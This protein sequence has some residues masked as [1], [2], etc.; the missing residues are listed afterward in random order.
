M[1][2]KLVFIANNKLFKDRALDVTDYVVDL[3]Q[4]TLTV[5]IPI[6]LKK[7]TSWWKICSLDMSKCDFY[8]IYHG[9]MIKKCRG[10][11]HECLHKDNYHYRVNI[12]ID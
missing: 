12:T 7:K 8:V 9:L 5:T 3:R 2:V 1:S 11:K 10:S 6:R 4:L